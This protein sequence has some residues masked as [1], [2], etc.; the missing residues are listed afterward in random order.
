MADAVGELTNMVSGDARAQLQRLGFDFS[1]AILTVIRGKNHSVR[2]NP[3]GGT[4]VVI[5][6]S[7]EFGDFFVEASFSS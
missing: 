5:P 1:A 2:H 3:Q 7:T 6:F 4:T